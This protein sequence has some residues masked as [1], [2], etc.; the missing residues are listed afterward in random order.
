MTTRSST[1]R[2]LHL[3]MKT[4][5]ELRSKLFA[6]L[7]STISP[8]LTDS[9]KGSLVSPPSPPFLLPSPSSFFFFCASRAWA[10][11]KAAPSSF[12]LP[13]MHTETFASVPAPL[14]SEVF[15]VTLYATI[16]LAPVLPGS[17]STLRL[18]A[19]KKSPYKKKVRSCVLKESTSTLSKPHAPPNIP[20]NCPPNV[21]LPRNPISNFEILPN[22]NMPTSRLNSS[23]WLRSKLLADESNF[24]SPDFAP[25]SPY[26][27][28]EISASVP[29]PRTSI[30]RT[31]TLYRC[32]AVA[33]ALGSNVRT[34]VPILA[35]SHWS[36][37][38]TY[39]SPFA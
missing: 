24:N 38:K 5:L 35:S 28:T 26:K 32:R 37:T 21:C 23:V 29:A 19:F 16:A 9:V 6:L 8:L 13:N 7:S 14:M 22:C 15:T 39:R 2:S 11:S 34:V 4:S 27:M 3:M 17:N 10:C 20:P 30:V 18:D 12:R 1:P 36:A 33:A 31:V 25:F